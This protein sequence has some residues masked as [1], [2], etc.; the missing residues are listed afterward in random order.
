MTFCSNCG[1]E[2]SAQAKF[3]ASCGNS[4]AGQAPVQAQGYQTT[5]A[6]QETRTSRYDYLSDPLLRN[7]SPIQPDGSLPFRLQEGEVI[8]KAFK[9]SKRVIVKFATGSLVGVFFLLFILVPLVLNLASSANGLG[10]KSA[11][12][13]VY[14]VVGLLVLIFL[15][16]LIFGYLGYSKYRYWITNHR[17]IGKRGIIGYS[18][19]SMPL[20]NVADVIMMRGVMDRILGIASLYVQPIGGSGMMI[21]MRGMGLNRYSGNNSFMGLQPNEVPELQQLIFHLRDL[22]KRE[23]GRIL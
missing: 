13:G 9:P 16:G 5:G 20:E 19:D 18:L 11:L 10:A 4:L 2:V 15:I 22:R 21:P 6:Q 12:Y 7:Y 17:T 23:T 14:I 3:C 1:T 8:L